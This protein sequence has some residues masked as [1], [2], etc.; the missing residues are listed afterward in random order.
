MSNYQ[1][2][3]VVRESA[4]DPAAAS[5]TGETAPTTT[6]PGEPTASTPAPDGR[7]QWLPEK[8]KSPEDMA[9][10]YSE[11]EKRFS[12]APKSDTTIPK[13]EAAPQGN[14]LLDSYA[15]E[16]AENGSLSEE[17]IKKLSAQG[18]PEGIVNNYLEGLNAISERQA[19][20]IYGLVGGEEQYTSMMEWASESLEESEIDAFNSI[21]AQKNPASMQMAVRG[22]RARFEQENGKPGRLIQGETTGVS[23]G[24][25]RSVA[26]VVE[27]MKDPRYKKDPAYRRDVEARLS[28]S[29]VFT[30]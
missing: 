28:N 16:Y 5:L 21:M 13:G 3:T 14:L 15:K 27:A 1:S 18:I 8:F 10:A 2:T 26:E 29:N 12:S 6:P 17:S 23:G 20:Q 9:K 30:S 25:F 11:L 19:Q 7:P 22:L 24:S 4:P